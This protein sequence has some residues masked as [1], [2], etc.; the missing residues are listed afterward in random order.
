LITLLLRLIAPTYAAEGAPAQQELKIYAL[1]NN[2]HSADF[3]VLGYADHLLYVLRAD[4]LSEVRRVV[5][6]GPPSLSRQIPS[7]TVEAL[8]NLDIVIS[9]AHGVVGR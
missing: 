6:F 2:P 8:R 4:D 5:A 9:Q 1:G 7:D 3:F